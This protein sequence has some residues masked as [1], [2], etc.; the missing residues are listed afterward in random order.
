MAQTIKSWQDYMIASFGELGQ[1]RVGTNSLEVGGRDSGG[2]FQPLPIGTSIA[3][4]AV[5][6]DQN[7]AVKATYG[8]TTI[9]TSDTVT[10]GTTKLTINGILRGLT[11]VTPDMEDSDSTKL[12]ILDEKGYVM[13]DSGTQAESGTYTKMG[14]ALTT[15]FQLP[16][17][18]TT[19]L[20]FTAEGTQSTDRK[21][22][23]YIKYS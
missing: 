8:T 12:E 7:K 1:A 22:I 14:T 9:V 21:L 13:Y 5:L 6:V 23:Y 16:F 20:V 2:V 17:Y 11:W 18:G 4:T 15:S 10:T 3:G 19:S